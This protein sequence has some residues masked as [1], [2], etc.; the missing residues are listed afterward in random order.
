MKIQIFKLIIFLIFI[1]TNSYSQYKSIENL[2]EADAIDYLKLEGYGYDISR[3]EESDGRITWTG[4]NGNPKNRI[5]VK[6]TFWPYN[7]GI[8]QKSKTT[9]LKDK[10]DIDS[11]I[12]GLPYNLKIIERSDSKIYAGDSRDPEKTTYVESLVRDDEP[13]YV[14]EYT[15]EKYYL[16]YKNEVNFFE[17]QIQISDIGFQYGEKNDFYSFLT[18]DTFDLS[19]MIQTFMLDYQTYIATEA[20]RFYRKGNLDLGSKYINSA[21]NTN[22]PVSADFRVLENETIAVAVGMNNDKEINIVVNPVSW[23]NYSEAK[24]FYIIYHELGHDAFNLNHGNGGKMMYNYAD[25]DVTWKDFIDDRVRMFDSYVAT[26]QNKIP[27]ETQNNSKSESE[28]I[29][30][31][32]ANLLIE[33]YKDVIKSYKAK[34]FLKV[35]ELERRITALSKKMGY[36]MDYDT[37]TTQSLLFA[38]GFSLWSKGDRNKGCDYLNKYILKVQNGELVALSKKLVEKCK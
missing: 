31:L 13:Y 26:N 30:S 16:W 33:L 15:G 10:P 12:K 1:T 17:P 8:Q 3:T 38:I 21:L 27:N 28:N 9:V 29:S 25:K 2:T 37:E 35:V 34:E 6:Y 14:G 19:G 18:E 11:W 24:R 7:L 5:F 20:E 36:E 4:F 23:K 32:D 22:Q